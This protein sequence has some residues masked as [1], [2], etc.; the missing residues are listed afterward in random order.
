MIGVVINMSAQIF[1][2]TCSCFDR[3]RRK[4][5]RKWIGWLRSD[6]AVK[7]SAQLLKPR[8]MFSEKKMNRGVLFAALKGSTWGDL[9]F[10]MMKQMS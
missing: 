1:S 2:L 4:K 5:N 8:R 3:T 6:F 10:V 9:L 7:K